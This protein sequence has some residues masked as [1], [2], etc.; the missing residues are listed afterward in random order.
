MH[1]FRLKCWKL[2]S[3]VEATGTTRIVVLWYPFTVH[4]DLL[5][6]SPQSV[7]IS[8]RCLSTHHVV[9]TSFVYGYNTIIGHRTLWDSL[10]SWAPIGP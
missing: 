2:V 1:R 7:H 3:N 6:F 9:A 8:I 5:D 10:K 4:V